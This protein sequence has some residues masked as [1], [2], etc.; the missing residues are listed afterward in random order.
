MSLRDVGCL[1]GF[2]PIPM[3]EVHGLWA[4]RP[5]GTAGAQLLGMLRCNA[6]SGL[7][8]VPDIPLPGA[9]PQAIYVRALRAH[10]KYQNKF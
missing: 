9:A 3:A 1:G 5:S 8:M 4:A 6:P 10:F 7:D 2:F